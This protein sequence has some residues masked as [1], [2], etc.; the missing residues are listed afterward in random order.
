MSQKYEFANTR[1]DHPPPLAKSCLEQRLDKQQ[2]PEV[3]FWCITYSR[4]DIKI[5]TWE[6]HE[7]TLLWTAQVDTCAQLL[8]MR[9]IE[10]QQRMIIDE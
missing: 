2:I 9:Q 7:A 4:G 1:P 8:C 3:S 6:D 5:L 10:S